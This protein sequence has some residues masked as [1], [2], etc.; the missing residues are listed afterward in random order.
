MS[1]YTRNKGRQFE[2]WC[3][4]VI[5]NV[6][7][8]S[9]GDINVRSKSA[10]GC[11]LWVKEGSRAQ[12]PYCVEAKNRKRLNLF[13]AFRQAQM[14]TYDG[15]LPVVF[16]HRDKHYLAVED[17]LTF[18]AKLDVLHDLLGDK[19][20]EEVEGRINKAKDSIPSIQEAR[21]EHSDIRK[22]RKG[23]SQ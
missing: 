23:G 1:K 2:F 11:D 9:N 10:A 7:G 14:N 13:E 15:Y 21:L 3:R 19:W 22:R 20:M 17:L 12:F 16:C 8:L 18:L 4:E 5:E 6:L